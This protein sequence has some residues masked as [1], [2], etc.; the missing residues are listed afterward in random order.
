MRVFSEDS[1]SKL[2]GEFCR[3]L[4]DDNEDEYYGTER[5]MA[6]PLLFRLCEFLEIPPMRDLT[7]LEKAEKSLSAAYAAW[8][9]AVAK[10]NQLKE[11][12]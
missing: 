10:V 3:D 6:E 12:A 4:D 1:L 5:H 11:Q 7:E 2:I 8:Q 9:A